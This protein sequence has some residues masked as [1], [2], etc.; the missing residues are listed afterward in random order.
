MNKT[1]SNKKAYFEYQIIE[2]FEAGIVLTGL[3]IKAIR[4]G[5]VNLFGSYVKIMG[6]EAFWIGG[7]VEVAEGDSQRSRKL[8]LHQKE[9][10]KLIGK[11]QEEGSALVPI[12]LYLKKGRAKLLVGIGKGLKKHDK[13]DKIRKRDL[14]REAE[15]SIKN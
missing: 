11:S 12:K 3:E 15:R 7:I 14:D 1:F 5:R 10:K 13:R 9:I 8:L 4:A 2:E 6:G